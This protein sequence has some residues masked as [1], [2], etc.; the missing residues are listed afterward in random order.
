MRS[1]CCPSFRFVCGLFLVKE[2]Y[3][4]TLLSVCVPPAPNLF[5]FC[6]VRV[7]SKGSRLLVLSRSSYLYPGSAKD[8][9]PSP[10]VEGPPLVSCLLLLIRS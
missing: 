1:P 2:A 8:L 5:V 9:L 3:E 4:V 10:H 7:V 6:A